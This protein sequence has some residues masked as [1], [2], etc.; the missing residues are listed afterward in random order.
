MPLVV[1][2]ITSN[3]SGGKDEW[4]NKL[5]GKKI[6]DSSSN[7][8]VCLLLYLFS[9][10]SVPPSSSSTL[11]RWFSLLS[12]SRRGTNTIDYSASQRKTSQKPT[13]S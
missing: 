12:R 3:S 8:T 13:G 2:G 9:F 6:S 1:P 7:E 5:V 10:R 4:L 11:C